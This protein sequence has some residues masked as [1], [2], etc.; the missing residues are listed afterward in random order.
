MEMSRRSN[1]SLRLSATA[2]AGAGQQRDLCL[3]KPNWIRK[4]PLAAPDGGAEV[5]RVRTYAQTDTDSDAQRQFIRKREPCMS[6]PAGPESHAGAKKVR[7][8]TRLAEKD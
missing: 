3:A 5:D 2:A 1:A 4:T 8:P 6:C 7:L